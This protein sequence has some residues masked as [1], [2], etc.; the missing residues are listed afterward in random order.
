MVGL[1]RSFLKVSFYPEPIVKVQSFIRMLYKKILETDSWEE[2][3]GF[4]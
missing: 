3:P 2:D 4:A 1:P